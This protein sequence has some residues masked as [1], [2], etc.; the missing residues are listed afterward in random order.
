M[1]S[2]YLKYSLE[3]LLEDKNFI[4]W[5]IRSDNKNEWNN[6]IDKH[7]EFRHKAQM[8]REIIL[9]LQDTYETLDEESVLNL[10]QNI[11]QFEQLHKQNVRRI[12]F[13]KIFNWAA[14]VLLL[15]SLGTLGYHFMNEKEDSFTFT[16]DTVRN[17]EALLVLSNGN[18]IALEEDNSTIAVNNNTLTINNDSVIDLSAR[19]SQNSN[20]NQMNEVVIPYGKQTN[21]TLADG[22]KVWLNAG[23]RLA[24]PTKFTKKNRNVFLEGEAYFEV[25]KNESRPFIVNVPNIKIRVLGTRFD[26]S[27]YPGDAIIETVLLE[28]SVIMGNSKSFGLNKNEVILKPYQ[29]G[30]FD[31][32]K[33]VIDVKDEPNAQDY[34]AW[35][36]GWFQF[37]KE[38]LNSIFIKLERYYNID[39]QTENK[40]IGSSELI[41]GK[42]DLKD[43][44]E[45]VLKVLTD[46]SALDYRIVDNKVLVNVKINEMKNK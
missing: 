23:S 38:S 41:S 29:K 32:E 33:N 37:S 22:T 3:D 26:V 12:K 25:I 15:I 9:L 19:E 5:V 36:E 43:S 6:F 11:D 4:A 13:R 14:F 44:L 46:I 20:E 21:L 8:A 18:E 17:K 42:L 7:P 40:A 31:K 16:P 2:K 10:W 1:D 27:A 24:F 30:R 39:F 45:D 28:G 34:I 35:T